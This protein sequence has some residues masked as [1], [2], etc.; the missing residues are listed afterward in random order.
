[1]N[2]SKKILALVLCIALLFV[3]VVSF[4]YIAGH[5]NHECTGQDC[6][7]CTQIDVSKH[8]I[9]NSKAFYIAALYVLIVAVTTASICSAVDIIC[10]SGITLISLKVELLN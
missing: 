3:P 8:N 5:I 6:P 4:F 7:I 2:I 1:M 10:H 9:D